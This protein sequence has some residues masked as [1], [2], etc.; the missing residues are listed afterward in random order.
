[1]SLNL[2]VQ[3]RSAACYSPSFV[4]LEAAARG[5]A[6]ANRAHVNHI[7]TCQPDAPCIAALK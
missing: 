1:M 6:N 3:P 2:A 7:E 5:T 4:P